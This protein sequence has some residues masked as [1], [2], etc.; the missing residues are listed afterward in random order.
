MPAEPPPLEPPVVLDPPAAPVPPRVPAEPLPPSVE[1]WLLPHP[2][3]HSHTEIRA[4]RA[5]PLVMVASGFFIKGNTRSARRR[6]GWRG[7]CLSV[8]VTKLTKRSRK[9]SS[10]RQ[11]SSATKP[12]A[13]AQKPPA[14]SGKKPPAFGKT[15]A[16]SGEKLP[17]DAVLAELR[18]FGLEYPG[19]HTKSPW[20]DHLDLAVNDKT[21]AYMSVAGEPLGISCKLPESG[22]AA[23]ELPF[24]TPTAYGLGK[25]GWVTAKFASGETPPVG[26]LKAW[27]DESY[28]AQAPKKL[29]AN[30]EARR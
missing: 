15:T 30:L 4:T 8:A 17:A 22:L 21:F 9:T 5:L 28:R 3:T 16:A 23:L 25:S 11:T 7:I 24:A 19:A 26:L 12:K 27:I 10:K 14:A 13:A 6:G 1:D 18:A 2:A 29:V 20:P